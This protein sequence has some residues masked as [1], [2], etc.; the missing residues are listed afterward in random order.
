YTT[1]HEA[2]R[3]AAGPDEDPELRPSQVS[4]TAGRPSPRA[5]QPRRV[6]RP[7]A[8]R[9]FRSGPPRFRR[10]TV[11]PQQSCNAIASRIPPDDTLRLHGRM[12]NNPSTTRRPATM[13][14]KKSARSRYLVSLTV[15]VPMAFS[16]AASA[17]EYFNTVKTKLEAG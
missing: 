3:L 10:R 15:I 2:A 4:G 11:T 9:R 14:A 12:P 1:P 8:P 6:L 17:Q 7:C 5:L 16:A 13:K